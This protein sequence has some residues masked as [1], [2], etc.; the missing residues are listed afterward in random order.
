M[1]YRMLLGDEV[2]KAEVAAEVYWPT[3]VDLFPSVVLAVAGIALT[4]SGAAGWFIPLIGT[5]AQ[6][7]RYEV[8]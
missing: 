8:A 3:S 2:V 6:S 7:D 1:V 5:D 4:G